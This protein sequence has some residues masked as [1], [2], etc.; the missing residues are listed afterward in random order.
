M[1]FIPVQLRAPDGRAFRVQ[2]DDV[3]PIEAVKAKLILALNLDSTKKYRLSLIDAL[4]VE[5]NSRIQ[6]DE[7][8]EEAIRG[9]EAI[10]E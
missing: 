3:A 5:S 4:R 6:I 7:V 8:E 9:L 1:A 2:V 10:A